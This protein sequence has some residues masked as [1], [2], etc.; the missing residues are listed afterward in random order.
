M[1]GEKIVPVQCVECGGIA[2]DRTLRGTEIVFICKACEKKPCDVHQKWSPY[3][4]R[5]GWFS[6][7]RCGMVG[8]EDEKGAFVPAQCST[9]GK[10]AMMVDDGSDTPSCFDHFCGVIAI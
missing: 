5:E 10:P 9:C 1:E 7:D 4:R 2:T 3:P 8:R 6:C